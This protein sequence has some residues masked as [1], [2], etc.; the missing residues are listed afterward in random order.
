[1]SWKSHIYQNIRF[2]ELEIIR[3]NFTE[4]H[5]RGCLYGDLLASEPLPTFTAG[6][7]ARDEDFLRKKTGTDIVHVGRGGQWTYHGPGQIV[8]YPIV[9]LKRVSGSSRKVSWFLNRF[10]QAIAEGLSHVGVNTT[11]KEKPFG[12]YVGE[13]KIASFGV[14]VEKGVLSHGVAIY[15]SDQSQPFRN[16]HPCGA[17]KLEFTSVEQEVGTFDWGQLHQTLLSKIEIAL[18]IL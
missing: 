6:R 8:I 14:S 17:P 18:P 7:G 12:L 4:K 16:I 5:Q 15:G 9:S 13:K 11:G 10:R 1:M 3:R 2:T